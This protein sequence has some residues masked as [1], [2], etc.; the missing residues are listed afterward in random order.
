MTV[1]LLLLLFGT[2]TR[3]N[4]EKDHCGKMK[5]DALNVVEAQVITIF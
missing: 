2:P 1:L 3:H 4:E 5:V